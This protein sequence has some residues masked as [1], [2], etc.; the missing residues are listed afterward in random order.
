[1]TNEMTTDQQLGFVHKMNDSAISWSHYTEGGWLLVTSRYDITA[2]GI[3]SWL[4][5][6]AGAI[7]CV[8]FEVGSVLTWCGVVD[9]GRQDSAQRWMT[10]FWNE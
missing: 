10:Q 7:T 2:E 3:R 9:S 4:V 5:G 8:V 6:I 1:M